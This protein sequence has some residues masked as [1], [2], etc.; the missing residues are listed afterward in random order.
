VLEALASA[1]P[2]LRIELFSTVPEWFFADSLSVP[3][4]YHY[5]EVDVGLVQR[6]PFTVDLEATVRRLE[7]FLP[8]SPAAIDPLA[9][10]VED[11]GCALVLCDI[12]PAGLVTGK[13]VG[14]PT[15]L[16]ENFTWDWIYDGYAEQCPALAPFS[17]LLRGLA[18]RADLRIQTIPVCLPSRAARTVPP[19][20]RAPRTSPDTVRRRLGV[21]PSAPLVLVTSGGIPWRHQ[22]LGELERRPGLF[23]VLPGASDRIER[24]GG[25]IALPHRSRF[26]HPDLVHASDAVVGKLGYST[27]AEVYAAG[28]AFG[29]VP[30]PDFR[31][32]EPLTRFALAEM[33]AVA[34]A[35]DTLESGT[36]TDTVEALLGLPRHPSGG[37]GG[38]LAAASMIAKLFG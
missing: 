12:S 21:P 34:L 7:R 30:R 33:R 19:V 14:L 32:S 37:G 36:W 31:E 1:T 20:S 35:P 38:A 27:L 4:R 15:V 26:F 16:L 28:C 24:R 23:F 9:R 10:Q 2:G 17:E 18:P 11:A 5:A 3:F 29:F 22:S 25:L 6:D 8:L 13:T